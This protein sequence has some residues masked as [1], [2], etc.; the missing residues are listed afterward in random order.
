M[1]FCCPN[2]LLAVVNIIRTQYA[3]FYE[4][5]NVSR[6]KVYFY[7]V[8]NRSTYHSLHLCNI[9]VHTSITDAS[10]QHGAAWMRLTPLCTTRA[11]LA[12][13]YTASVVL[14]RQRR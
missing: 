9:A 4:P 10:V 8:A 14:V 7:S 11:Q 1:L 6:M 13:T 12:L 3:Y 2:L 5:Y